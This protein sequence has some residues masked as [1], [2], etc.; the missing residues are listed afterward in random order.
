MME[1]HAI[2]GFLGLPS[3]W[4]LFNFPKLHAYNLTDPAIAPSQDG[5]WGWAKRFN[6]YA[7]PKQGIL[8]GYSLGG[9]L[10]MHAL[11]E[12]PNQW[13]GAI[14]VSSHPGL[15]TEKEKA[16]RIQ[17][18]S[19]WAERFEKEPW[20]KV[21]QDWNAQPVFAGMSFKREEKL[22][23]RKDLGHQLR[24]FSRGQQD[25]LSKTIQNFQ[26]PIL[27]ICGQLDPLF[28]AAAKDLNFSHPLSRVE[29]VE[30]AAHRV[31]WEQPDQFLKV[32]QS[33]INEV[34]SCL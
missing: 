17:A 7:Q 26:L 22:F 3:D 25:D 32:T 29:F 15:K 14:I 21:I 4:Q 31:P 33:F 24:H 1:I 2:H 5:L 11:L 23:S 34:S 16:A 13:K 10:A 8:L 18:D 12:N 27:W 30:G 19:A 6:H 20:E 28:K 9:R